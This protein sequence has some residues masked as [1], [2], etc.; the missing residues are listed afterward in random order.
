MRLDEDGFDDR[1]FG[2]EDGDAVR[3]DL[4]SAR[5]DAVALQP[6]GKIVA[7]GTAGN[8]LGRRAIAAGRRARRD[9]RRL[10]SG[11]QQDRQADG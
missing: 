11:R 7:V 9:L 4:Y 1:E 2:G 3:F 8:A 6:D 10:R 5:A